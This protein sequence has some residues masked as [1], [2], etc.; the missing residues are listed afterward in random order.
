MKKY[1]FFILVLLLSSV[2]KSYPQDISFSDS[3]II[4]LITCSPGKEVYA[5]FGH[6]AIR[7]KDD[8]NDI[9]IVF[10]YGIFDFNSHNFYL[11]FVKGETDYKLAA[12]DF[13]YFLPEYV[14]RNSSVWEQEL[15]LTIE[16]KRKL[17][18]LL[19]VNYEPQNRVYRYNFI[20]DNCST[21]PRDI[22]TKAIN[23]KIEYQLIPEVKTFREWVRE[24]VGK[25]TWVMFGIDMIF[26]KDSDRDASRKESMFLPEVLMSQFQGAVVIE[27]DKHNT[28][29]LVSEYHTL[30]EEQPQQK[31]NSPFILT[32]IVICVFLLI[33]GITLIF[34]RHK[35]RKTCKIFDTAI[36]AI[37][38][39]IGI[40]AF[41]L[42]FLS[43]HPMV[44]DNFNL[45]W[46]NPFFFIAAI[47]QW[48][49]PLRSVTFIIQTLNVILLF[50]ALI[51]LTQSIQ[52]LNIAFVPLILLL[53]IRTLIYLRHRIKK[54]QAKIKHEK[55]SS[56]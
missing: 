50:I 24:Y 36:F 41:Y 29:N 3:T 39:L 46:L 27:S 1:T 30:N 5:K 10:N 38:G 21:R 34:F 12:Y 49:K 7:V 18:E 53:L 51:V 35:L 33:I 45:L 44:K 42:T 13:I 11:K 48:V 32:P 47:I 37:I 8:V 28:H 26:G 19:L 15:N 31:E 52:Y 23:G 4:S 16:E 9:D 43:L 54:Y 55:R 14:E 56:F 25:D 2:L 20:Y 40:M 22:I 17:I 6:T